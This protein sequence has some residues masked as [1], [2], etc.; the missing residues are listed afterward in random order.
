[1]GRNI[2]RL[3]ISLVLIAAGIAGARFLI[4]TKPTVNKRPPVKMEPL[5]RTVTLQP[6]DY[7]L[8]IPAMGNVI[9]AREI[10]LETQIAGEVIYL[11][12]DF[13]EGGM[14]PGGT[15]IVQINPKDYELAIMQKQRALSEAEYSL[16]LEQGHQ[17]VAR[18]EWDLLY[19]DQKTTEVESDLALRK[20]H[21]EKVQAEIAAARAELEQAKINLKRTALAAPF[22]VLVLNKYVDLGSQV[23][24]QERLA[25]LVGTD[26]FWIQVPLPIERLQRIQ[27]PAG[28][29]ETG[30]RV[31]IIYR[32]DNVRE[33]R[34]IRLLPDLSKEGR[35]ARLLIEVND[36]LDL[37]TK[38]KKRPMLLIGEYVRVLI[39]GETLL[40]VYRI[41]R[42]ALHNDSEVWI[43][44]EESRLAIRPVK[45][46]WRDEES[47]V[48]QDGFKPGERLIVS[49]LAAPVAGMP[50]RIEEPDTAGQE[51]RKQGQ[52][53][54]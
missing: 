28:R 42:P 17:D 22:N 6:E 54:K 33:G 21:L 48:V 1:M 35:M 25:D 3:I 53:S 19:G 37:Q 13:I 45:T 12:P 27:M 39:E 52:E 29:N 7:A 31:K 32:E 30:S 24:S 9:P 51:T 2:L 15:K 47:V 14:L 46:I 43:V 5:V 34:V 40:D 8:N 16:K 18:Q 4:A 10:S 36:P 11:H 38:G 41:P 20:P 49:G 26:V 50:V 44:D 23:T